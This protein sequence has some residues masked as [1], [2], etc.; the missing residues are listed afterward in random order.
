MHSGGV[1]PLNSDVTGLNVVLENVDA[2]KLQLMFKYNPFILVM[3]THRKMGK[4]G[5]F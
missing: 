1:L 5:P 3:Y 4:A 2:L